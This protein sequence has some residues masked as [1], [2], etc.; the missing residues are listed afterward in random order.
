ML[1]FIASLFSMVYLIFLS[2]FTGGEI[3]REYSHQFQI[4][5]LSDNQAHIVSRYSVDNQHRYYFVR[6]LDGG[7]K[8]GVDQV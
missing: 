1:L 5:A 8:T 7:K 2:F 6:N 3:E 4:Q